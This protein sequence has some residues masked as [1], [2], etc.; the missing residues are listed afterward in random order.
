MEF[1]NPS[2]VED[3]SLTVPE[4]NN[5][6]NQ[7]LPISVNGRIEPHHQG[8]GESSVKDQIK[9][10]NNVFEAKKMME[11]ELVEVKDGDTKIN[12]YYLRN[13]RLEDEVLQGLHTMR[14]EFD[15]SMVIASQNKR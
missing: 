15:S 11:E 7:T 8:G 5:I 13:I 12:Q 9:F 2:Y 10:G 6:S 4:E 1:D 3:A 14:Q